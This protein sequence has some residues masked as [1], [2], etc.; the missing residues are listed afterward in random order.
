MRA[1]QKAAKMADQS[2]GKMAEKKVVYSAAR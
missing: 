1:D 2:G